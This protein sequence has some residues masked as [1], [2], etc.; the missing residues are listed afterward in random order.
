MLALAVAN[1][2]LLV[3]EYA[4]T[5]H[6]W[7]ALQYGVLVIVACCYLL[8]GLER[9]VGSVS[10]TT[11]S[12]AGYILNG[13]LLFVPS[14]L[15]WVGNWLSIG[16]VLYL[17]VALALVLYGIGYIRTPPKRAGASS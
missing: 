12:G 17:L 7:D 4:V 6:P 15:G 16:G 2:F 8:G 10:D 13:L 11:I 3:G 14:S 9:D 5:S 1:A